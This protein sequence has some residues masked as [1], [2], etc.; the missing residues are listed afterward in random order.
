MG[1]IM[2]DLPMERSTA[3]LPAW[4]CVNIDLFGPIRIRDNCVKKGPRIYKKVWGFL[5]T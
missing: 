2:G 3:N 1:Q 4:L 5:Y